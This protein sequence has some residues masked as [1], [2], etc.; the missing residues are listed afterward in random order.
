MKETAS[1]ELTVLGTPSSGLGPKRTGKD[2]DRLKGTI[3]SHCICLCVYG[4]DHVIH[5]MHHLTEMM[6]LMCVS[7]VVRTESV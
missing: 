1:L 6:C 5:M 4:R 2:D 3:K 7:S